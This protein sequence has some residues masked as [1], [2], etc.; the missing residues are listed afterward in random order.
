MNN[1]DVPRVA[2]NAKHGAVLSLPRVR[3]CFQIAPGNGPGIGGVDYEVLLNGVVQGTGK[4]NSNG[5][6][7]LDHLLLHQKPIL[8]IFD[9]EYE[10]EALSVLEPVESRLGRIRR[11]NLLGYYMGFLLSDRPKDPLGDEPNSSY[12]QG[13]LNF[14]TATKVYDA[15]GRLDDK[16]DTVGLTKA[17]TAAAGE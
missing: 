17:L 2:A 11:L 9:T 3:I 1:A 7:F 4:T 13:L 12:L 5:E 10:I 6:V 14:K 16:E 8:R 15:K